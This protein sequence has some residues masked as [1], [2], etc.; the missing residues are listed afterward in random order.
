MSIESVLHEVQQLTEQEKRTVLELLQDHFAD[1]SALLSEEELGV[2][3]ARLE[4]Y[5]VHPE[6]GVPWEEMKQRHGL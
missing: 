2:V 1:E 3:R 4:H 6:T 5:H